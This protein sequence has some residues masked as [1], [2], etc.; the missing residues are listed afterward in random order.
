M[1]SRPRVFGDTER[2]KKRK[3]KVPRGTAAL[4]ARQLKLSPVHIGKVV[5]GERIG[6][7]EVREALERIEKA[8]REEAE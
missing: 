2:P 6:G 5:K 8:E 1:K 4:V 7:S 3:Y